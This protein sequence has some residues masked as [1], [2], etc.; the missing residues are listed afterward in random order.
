MNKKQ[1]KAL[2]GL[3][4]N[5]LVIHKYELTEKSLNDC[6]LMN[7]EYAKRLDQ[8]DVPWVIQNQIAY[9]AENPENWSNYNDIVINRI[10]N[11]YTM[12]G[13]V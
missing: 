9:A 5:N 7:R 8:L 1:L 11:K 13:V 4:V 3:Y 6:I 2:H 10:V 12:K